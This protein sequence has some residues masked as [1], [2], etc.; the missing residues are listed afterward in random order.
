[1]I[2]LLLECVYVCMYVLSCFLYVC[3]YVCTSYLQWGMRCMESLNQFRKIVTLMFWSCLSAS[4]A[5]SNMLKLEFMR[6]ELEMVTSVEPWRTDTRPSFASKDVRWSTHTRLESAKICTV[7]LSPT[8]FTWK[9]CS[10]TL[11]TPL[12]TMH[13]PDDDDDDDDQNPKTTQFIPKWLISFQIA[14]TTQTAQ[15]MAFLVCIFDETRE[16]KL[17]V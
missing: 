16:I 5:P 12:K 9:L 15:D 4:E 11:L 14:P 17:G 6:S 3:M 1:M 10:I 8:P 2:E 13:L 7:S